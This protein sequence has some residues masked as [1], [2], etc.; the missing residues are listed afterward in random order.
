[1]KEKMSQIIMK[2]RF[3]KLTERELSQNIVK[4]NYVKLNEEKDESE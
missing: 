3:E 4:E 2:E 1:M